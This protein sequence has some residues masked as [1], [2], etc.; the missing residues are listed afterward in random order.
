VGLTEPSQYGA[1]PKVWESEEKLTGPTK[2]GSKAGK[3]SVAGEDSGA[4]IARQTSARDVI[5]S[6]CLLVLAAMVSRLETLLSPDIALL[7][8]LT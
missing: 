4:V 1:L 8:R 7:S 3:A 6:N 5:E 2:E